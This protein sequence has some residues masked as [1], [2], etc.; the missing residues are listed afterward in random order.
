MPS[1]E[2]NQ[3]SPSCPSQSLWQEMTSHTENEPTPSDNDPL[4]LR[5]KVS[6][7]TGESV[8][9]F[10]MCVRAFSDQLSA[11]DSLSDSC[12]CVS[13][14]VVCQACATARVCVWKCV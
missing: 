3:Y 6:R 4:H 1:F 2:V 5:S 7:V 9:V 14:P 10:E 12:V 13:D 8:C 11:V